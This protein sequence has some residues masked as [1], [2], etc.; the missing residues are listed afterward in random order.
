MRQC[1]GCQERVAKPELIRIV[2]TPE[3]EIMLDPS[4]KKNGRGAYTCKKKECL[5]KAFKKGAFN[6]TFKAS[7]DA[8]I[9]DRLKAEM[10]GL[11][12]H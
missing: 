10:E 1:V 4:G 7:F 6:R 12:V 3:G 9:L 5:E 8:E 11:D 2:H